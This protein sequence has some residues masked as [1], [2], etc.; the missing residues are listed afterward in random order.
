MFSLCQNWLPIWRTTFILWV[1]RISSNWTRTIFG[2]IIF[3][4]FAAPSLQN[5][6]FDLQ[7]G[8]PDRPFVTNRKQ[9]DLSLTF[10]SFKYA[11]PLNFYRRYKR[12]RKTT[13]LTLHHRVQR[14]YHKCIIVG[15]IK[16]NVVHY[17]RSLLHF[18]CIRRVVSVRACSV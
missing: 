4:D 2:V 16:N 17:W 1:F 13:W 9:L 10:F 18:N 3:Q 15:K 14:K 6:A 7:K 12:N 11:M 8:Q 5:A